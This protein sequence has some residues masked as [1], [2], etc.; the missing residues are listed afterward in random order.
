MACKKWQNFLE[1][2]QLATRRYDLAVGAL[3][4]G[5]NPEFNQAWENAERARQDCNRSRAAL[6]HH[7]HEHA[8]VKGIEDRLAMSASTQGLDTDELVL[9]DQGQSGG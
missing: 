3:N 5:S 9:G 4:S 1:D 8:C 6:L 2:Y 7:E